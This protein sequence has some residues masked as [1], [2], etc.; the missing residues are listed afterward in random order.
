MNVLI[1]LLIILLIIYI[2][3]TLS[4]KLIKE[5]IHVNKNKSYLEIMEYFCKLSYEQVYKDQILSFSSA[6]YRVEKDIL[7]TSKRNFVKLV[8]Q[9]MGGQ[10]IKYLSKFYG[11]TD[12][13]TQNMIIWF[14]IQ[15]DNDEVLKFVENQK[16]Q[17][18]VKQ[19]DISDTLEK[20]E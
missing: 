16:N 5:Y 4:L 8:H 20:S 3:V 10:I 11:T 19:T 6:G 1:I 13:L 2:I 15:L 18:D 14:N 17:E 7:E 9:L 12:N